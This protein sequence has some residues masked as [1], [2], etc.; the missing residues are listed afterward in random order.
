MRWQAVSVTAP[1]PDGTP[2]SDHERLV[3][4]VLADRDRVEALAAVTDL[5]AFTAAVV[6]LAAEHDLAVTPDDVAE[7][8]RAGDRRWIE[9]WI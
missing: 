7:A 4:L 6:A 9:R 1:D 3:A 2:R 8:L 5:D